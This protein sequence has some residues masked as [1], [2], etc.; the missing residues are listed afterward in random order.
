MGEMLAKQK[1]LTS[2]G[3]E[4]KI[5]LQ[6]AEHFCKEGQLSCP[7]HWLWKYRACT[8]APT[9]VREKKQHGK[10]MFNSDAKQQKI[11]FCG[12]FLMAEYLTGLS[13]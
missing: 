11:K 12:V 9:A 4:W 7:G 8:A 1:P 3:T 2:P 13:F 10:V 6:A 5:H